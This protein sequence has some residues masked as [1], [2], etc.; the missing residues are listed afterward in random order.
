MSWSWTLYRY[1]ARQFLIGVG[2]IFGAF[3]L[4]GVELFPTAQ[5]KARFKV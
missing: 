5:A 1:L 2:M 3:L 4:L